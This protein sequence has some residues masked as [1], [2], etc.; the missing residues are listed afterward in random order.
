MKVE[1]PYIDQFL[2]D[3][4]MSAEE[5]RISAAYGGRMD[6]GGASALVSQV[7]IFQSGLQGVIPQE[8]QNSYSKFVKDA[9]NK[10]DSEFTEY[11]RLKKKFEE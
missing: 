4:L 6:D 5:I 11:Q 1:K 10:E 3:L 9:K 7:S 2:A 8:W